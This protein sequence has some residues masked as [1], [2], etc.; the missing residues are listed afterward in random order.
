MKTLIVNKTLLNQ[1]I[2]D[3]LL[4]DDFHE[5]DKTSEFKDS[6][7]YLPSEPASLYYK[8]NSIWIKIRY[9]VYFE[10]KF[11]KYA[12]HGYVKNNNKIESREC[13]SPHHKVI[14]IAIT[15]ILNNNNIGEIV[16]ET[17]RK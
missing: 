17:I 16:G 2:N 8:H 1:I 4:S 5:L 15:D 10:N 7:L 9:Q 13:H 6:N 3:V 11:I 12:Y 14:S